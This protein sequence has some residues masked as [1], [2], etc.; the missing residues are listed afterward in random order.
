MFFKDSGKT[1]TVFDKFIDY[2]NSYEIL[3]DKQFGFRSKHS[4]YMAIIELVD[5][6]NTAVKTHPHTPPTHIHTKPNKQTKQNKK[7]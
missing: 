6:I 2:I 3:N 1:C 5:K 4:T 7:I